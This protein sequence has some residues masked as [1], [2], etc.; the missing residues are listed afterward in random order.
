MAGPH[1]APRGWASGASLR[2]RCGCSGQR[3]GGG[4]R[5]RANN[6]SA[7]LVFMA[8]WSPLTPSPPPPR[9]P[10]RMARARP[11]TGA[12]NRREGET[13]TLNVQ[14]RLKP[15]RLLKPSRPALRQDRPS[16]DYETSRRRLPQCPLPGM[17]CITPATP[18]GTRSA[19]KWTCVPS[20]QPSTTV[21]FP[22]MDPLFRL[23]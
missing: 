4:F 7:R 13:R 14:L 20:I 16:I 22:R 10:P 5:Q 21:P 8:V 6:S 2:R 18:P 19:S 15:L 1:L 23:S 12:S 17:S 9:F 11:A 3:L